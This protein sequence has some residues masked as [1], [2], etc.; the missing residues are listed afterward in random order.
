[1]FQ[2]PF[3]E[4]IILIPF[5]CLS[6]AFHS[7][8]SLLNFYLIIFIYYMTVYHNR[9][10]L[11]SLLEST[12]GKMLCSYIFTVVIICLNNWNLTLCDTID[13]NKTDVWINY[14]PTIFFHLILDTIFISRTGTAV[15]LCLLVHSYYKS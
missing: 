15:E 11:I 13:L 9:R 8:I 10:F 7:F 6:L 4:W 12:L 14:V 2:T 3:Q 5:T 1:M